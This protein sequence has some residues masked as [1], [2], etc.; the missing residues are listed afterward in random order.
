MSTL[1]EIMQASS[2]IDLKDIPNLEEIF[3]QNKELQNVEGPHTGLL[4][5]ENLY[6]NSQS[7]PQIVGVWLQAIDSKYGRTQGRIVE[8]DHGDEGVTEFI[9]TE[10]DSV[11]AGLVNPIE[12]TKSV[13][14]YSVKPG[15]RHG[16]DI[17]PSYGRWISIKLKY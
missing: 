8:H 13:A 14:V 6:S 9:I 16:S 11:Y 5:S 7:R 17:Q 10:G 1:K 2:Q 3:A 15:V 12:K 4:S